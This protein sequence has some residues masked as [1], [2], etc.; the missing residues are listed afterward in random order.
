MTSSF[1]AVGY[2]P[3]PAGAAYDETDWTDPSAPNSP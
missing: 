2:S 1:A 3:K